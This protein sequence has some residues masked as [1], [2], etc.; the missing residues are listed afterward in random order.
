[1]RARGERGDKHPEPGVMPRTTLAQRIF[2]YGNRT[3][4]FN[5]VRLVAASIAHISSAAREKVE[6]WGA[7]LALYSA[8][9]FD[10][11]RQLDALLSSFARMGFPS[12]QREQTIDLPS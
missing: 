7:A 5:A 2:V 11:K 4:I 8:T 6:N 10:M 9:L 3:V 1:M 12:G